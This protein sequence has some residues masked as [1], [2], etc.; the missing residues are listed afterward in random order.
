M[1][2]PP[3]PLTLVIVT[4]RW[5][6]IMTMLPQLEPLDEAEPIGVDTEDRDRFVS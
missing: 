1:T 4:Q 5:I 3:L 2:M 6:V